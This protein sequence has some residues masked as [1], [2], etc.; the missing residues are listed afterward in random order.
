MRQLAEDKA[1]DRVRSQD[2]GEEKRRKRQ[3]RRREQRQEKEEAGEKFDEDEPERFSHIDIVKVLDIIKEKKK[4]S[5][6]AFSF[7]RYVVFIVLYLTVVIIQRNAWD[8]ES[9]HGALDSYYMGEHRNDRLESQSFTSI[10][11]VADFYTWMEL[12]FLTNVYPLTSPNFDPLP[13][14]ERYTSLR[15]NR[16]VAGFRLVQRRSRRQD[17][18]LY[19]PKYDVFIPRGPD[20][21]VARTYFEGLVGPVDREPFF[22]AD[23][24]TKYEYSSVELGLPGSG[25]FDVGYFE[26]FDLDKDDALARLLKLKQNYWINPGTQWLRVEAVVYNHNLGIFGVVQFKLD[27]D[28]TGMLKPK[29]VKEIINASSYSN[30]GDLARFGLEITVAVLWLIYVISTVWSAIVEARLQRQ[31]WAYFKDGIN[32]LFAFQLLLFTL[33]GAIWIAIVNDPSR[34]D[35]DVSRERIL[36][37]SGQPPAFTS[38]VL[39]SQSYYIINGVN[40]LLSVFRLLGYFRVNHNLSMLTDTFALMIGELLQFGFLLLTMVVAFMLMTHVYFGTQLNLFSS[41]DDCFVNVLEFLFS[42]GNFFLLAQQDLAAAFLFYIPFV[43]IMIFVVS[44]ITIAIILE[45]YNAMQQS[46]ALL[47][48]SNIKDVVE[49]SFITQLSNGIL[50]SLHMF[51]CCMPSRWRVIET[52]NGALLDRFSIPSKSEVLELLEDQAD[53]QNPVI[54]FETL[55]GNLKEKQVTE[56][57]LQGIF[58]RYDAWVDP[59]EAAD[60]KRRERLMGEF[61]MIK[62]TIYTIMADQK[63][64]DAKISTL[65]EIFPTLP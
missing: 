39:L 4:N 40:V 37:K 48:K 13:P 1:R 15:F 50:R 7:M 65:L 33:I 63:R 26:F 9:M 8:A 52:S 45:G 11:T 6:L 60:S 59:E 64:L 38:V 56:E 54:L 58:D 43:F 19:D 23:G 16:L 32:V 51:R 47:L 44:N 5:A 55:V 36:D 28:N 18:N 30:Y 46:R 10:T 25:N 17:C 22:G 27:V 24:V 62:Q 3:K 57:R 31:T 35:L 2:R 29:F 49:L 20:G 21:C 12:N 53:Y 41:L 34:S 42:R 61:S 14:D